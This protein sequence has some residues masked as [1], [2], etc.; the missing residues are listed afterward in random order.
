MDDK[1]LDELID[2]AAFRVR[3]HAKWKQA[4]I[5]YHDK[6]TGEVYGKG[7]DEAY[8]KGYDFGKKAA[9]ESLKELRKVWRDY[10]GYKVKKDFNYM[11]ESWQAIENLSK[12]LGWNEEKT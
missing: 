6:K 3:C 8:V 7:Y 11:Y 5:D 12:K 1:K 9:A 2:A 4:I 10:E